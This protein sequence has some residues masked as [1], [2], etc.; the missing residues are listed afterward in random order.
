MNDFLVKLVNLFEENA[1]VLDRQGR[2]IFMNQPAMEIFGVDNFELV[3]GFFFLSVLTFKKIDSGEK[4]EDFRDFLANFEHNDEDGKSIAKF[5]VVKNTILEENAVFARMWSV[6]ENIILILRNIGEEQRKMREQMEFISTA[7]HEMR[8]PV[9]AIEGYLGLALNPTT[10]TIDERAKKYLESAH[11][12]SLRLGELFR[13]LL[14][15]TELDDGRERVN[16]EPVELSEII[17]TEVEMF[18]PMATAKQLDLQ[19][20]QSRINEEEKKF[21]LFGGV[22]ATKNDAKLTQ[23]LY[24]LIDRGCLH[25]ILANLIENAVKYTK[26]GGKIM[27]GLSGEKDFARITVSDTGIGIPAEDLQKIF[28]KF[29]RV[30]NSDTRE[31]GGTGLG[32]YIT[33][34]KVELLHGK[35]WAESTVGQSTSFIIELPR[36]SAAE[37]ERQ[38]LIFENNKHMLK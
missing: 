3:E 10:A 27:V 4:I 19:F 23:V 35:I 28:Q 15:V 37:F 26:G 11:Q 24:T 22:F 29:Y 30:D 5:N 33:K 34:R 13:D 38:K 16:L 7:S 8:T 12:A 20:E 21:R 1:L 32:L 31:V 17:K 36:I 18:L 9:A 14:D 25:E 6:N 2:V